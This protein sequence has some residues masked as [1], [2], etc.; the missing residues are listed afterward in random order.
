[1]QNGWSEIRPVRPADLEAIL[2]IEQAAMASP[3][4][5]GM[6]QAELNAEGGVGLVL[7]GVAGLNGYAFFRICPP[8]SELLH[9][10]VASQ[11]RRRGQ[12][13]VLLRT[14]LAHFA[15]QGYAT[16][17]LEVRASNAAALGLYAKL[18]FRQVGRRKGYYRQPDEDALLLN[19]NLTHW[20]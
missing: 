13:E 11:H 17:L 1:M 15:E 3:W 16:C 18:G 14:A 7:E 6:V 5:V 2:A 8:E 9:L 4:S 19:C 20:T 10:V 12:G